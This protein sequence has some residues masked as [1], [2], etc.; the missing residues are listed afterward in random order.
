ML[1]MNDYEIDHAVVVHANWTEDVV[2]LQGAEILRRLAD[3]A[4]ENSDGWHSWPKPARSAAKLMTLLQDRDRRFT[5]AGR[6]ADVDVTERELA[7]ALTPI[8]TFLTRHGVSEAER[9]WILEGV[10]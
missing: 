7:A 8:K 1:F 6:D 4:D 10:R 3:W 2:A 9:R 5:V